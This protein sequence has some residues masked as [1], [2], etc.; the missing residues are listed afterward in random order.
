M[1][2]LRSQKQVYEW[3]YRITNTYGLFIV[4]ELVMMKV[5]NL[6]VISRPHQMRGS[7]PT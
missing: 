2:S 3:W 7:I 5:V 6:G 1:N 4:K